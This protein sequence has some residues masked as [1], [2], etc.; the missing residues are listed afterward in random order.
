MA[1][2]YAQ[3]L[4]QLNQ[5]VSGVADKLKVSFEFFPP[6][7]QAA[8]EDLWKT[9][10]RLAALSPHFVS[11]T[12]GHNEHSRLRTHDIVK[13]IKHRTGVASVPHLTCID[14]PED[15]L[16]QI[17]QDYWDSGIRHIV[18]LRGD[19]QPGRDYTNYY[20]S[21]LVRMLKEV[22]DFDV[23]VAAY[24]EVHPEASSAQADL[25]A[26][27]RKV[28]QGASRAITQFFFDVE[29]FLRFR[30]RCAS[31]CIDAEI[32]PGLLPVTNLQTLKRFAALTNVS[33]PAWLLQRFEGLD[34]DAAT[35]SFLGASIAID[36]VR[37]LK[38]EG[39]EDFHFYTLNRADLSYAIC[40]MLG[41][42]GH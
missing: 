27:K 33:I 34:D 8:E 9:I 2:S 37:V 28:E 19:K 15:E 3:H 12:Y 4:E 13:N 35:R 10:E 25:I 40:H 42:R 36:Q 1:Y 6:N 21:D 38:H 17:A 16:K 11:V 26:L 39:V 29:S 7:S 18:A 22:A 24:P 23:S 41:F 20:A 32:I 14:T 31:A 5:S 30:D